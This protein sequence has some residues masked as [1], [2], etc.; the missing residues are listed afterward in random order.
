MTNKSKKICVAVIFGGKSAEH[1]ISLMSAKNVVNALD[2]QKYDVLLI[3]I[4][5]EG[6][7]RYL[8]D[9]KALLNSGKL[10]KFLSSEPH[11]KEVAAIPGMGA[12]TLAIADQPTI[13]DVVFPVLHGPYGE[14][15]TIQGMLKLLDLPYV[16]P[17]ILGSSVCMDKEIMKKLLRDSGI[18]VAR[19]VTIRRQEKTQWKYAQIAKELGQTLFIKPANMGSSIGV[20]KVTSEED[21]GRAL[22]DA[23]LYDNK[24]LVEE[25]IIARE[26]ECSVL[27][28]EN[29]R[30]SLPG[31]VIVQSKDGF[32]SYDAKYVDDNGAT[33][34]I[35]APMHDG[36]IA[37]VQEV[38]IDAFK[39]LCC[40][41][42]SRVD[43]FVTKEEQIFV[44]ELNTIPG[45]TNISMYPK[46]WEVSGLTYKDLL[47]EL[48]Q[49][50]LAR[51]AR[52]KKLKILKA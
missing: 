46:M 20:H 6:H 50:A 26:I 25:Q 33:I 48:I 47:D 18:G 13:A 42:M 41:G 44:N 17:D 39:A 15:G 19:W 37:R 12:S 14:D 22:E 9:A 30:A 23:F 29:P 52:D 36:L 51:H 1:E 27:G 34:K 10:T 35:P 7:W 16:G 3:G 32:Y 49:L 45:F 8:E 38:A 5:P 21:F 40:E 24:V 4:T 28:N 43:M 2:P 11:T 31:E